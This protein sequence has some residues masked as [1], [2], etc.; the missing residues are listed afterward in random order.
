MKRTGDKETPDPTKRP[1]T[2]SD[3][4]FNLLQESETWDDFDSRQLQIA[5]QNLEK[6]I[7][8]NQESRLRHSDDPLKFQ[9]SEEDLYTAILRFK[10]VPEETE[11]ELRESPGIE[12][13][14]GL[15]GHENLDIVNAAVEVVLEWCE[16]AS[17]AATAMTTRL[18]DLELLPT[19]ISL[20]LRLEL[21]SDRDSEV[22][23]NVL[24][25]LECVFTAKPEFLTSQ[26]AIL[27]S[28]WALGE[29]VSSDEVF[30]TN[31]LYVVELLALVV[32]N[33]ENYQAVTELRGVEVVLSVAISHSNKSPEGNDEKELIANLFD[34]LSSLLLYPPALSTFLRIQGVKALIHLLR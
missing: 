3:V 25:L 30:T 8:R 1:A 22:L 20:L 24:S 16:G 4:V 28:K 5:L 32:S 14:V 6:S 26:N 11:T 34:C 21:A 23:Y 13:L 27:F 10:A 33:S 2:G 31:K 12:N 18:C 9:Q 29:L 7:C 19:T 17:P 15:M